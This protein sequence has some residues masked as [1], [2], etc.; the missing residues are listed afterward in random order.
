[1]PSPWDKCIVHIQSGR[2][3]Y[4]LMMA[5]MLGKHVQNLQ[6]L[7]HHFMVIV[8]CH[9]VLPAYYLLYACSLFHYICIP[10]RLHRV[11]LPHHICAYLEKYPC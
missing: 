1:M 11:F 3:A 7:R 10:V 8:A 5:I 6:G 2:D 9:A 4:R